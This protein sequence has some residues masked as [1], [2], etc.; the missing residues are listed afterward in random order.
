MLGKC[1]ASFLVI[2][3]MDEVTSSVPN[4]SFWVT[5]VIGDV[6]KE[7]KECNKK[8]LTIGNHGRQPDIVP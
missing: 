8:L 3:K 7:R 6:G 1:N 2:A 5:A 4:V